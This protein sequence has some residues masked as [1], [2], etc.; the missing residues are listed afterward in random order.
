[1]DSKNTIFYISAKFIIK[2]KRNLFQKIW[3]LYEE[4]I[5]KKR[6]CIIF[7]EEKIDHKSMDIF[8]NLK[9]DYFLQRICDNINKLKLL[10][11]MKYNKKLQKR[12]NLNINDYKEYSKLYSSIEIELKLVDNIYDR[13]IN[14][15]EEDM[16]YYHI[17]IDN[18]NE[19]INIYNSKKNE[20]LNNIKILINYQ[21]KSLKKLFSKCKCISSI[22][23]KQFLRTNIIDMSFMFYGCT[24]LK[25]LPYIYIFS[26]W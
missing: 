20:K 9:S 18:S 11:I 8:K 2:N 10:K 5:F 14:I 21:I 7:T 17:Y 13:F 1:M 15:S 25:E 4:K 6:N 23:F 24:S 12:A 22:L 3:F 16:E 26:N 19:E